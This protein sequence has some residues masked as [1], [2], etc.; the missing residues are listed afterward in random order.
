MKDNYDDKL[1]SLIERRLEHS[2]RCPGTP[3]LKVFEAILDQ[4]YPSTPTLDIRQ[5]LSRV[6]D[7]G[8][9]L[10]VKISET[11]WFDRG[12]VAMRYRILFPNRSNICLNL[13]S[14]VQKYGLRVQ[15]YG[16]SVIMDL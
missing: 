14:N 7:E 3:R 4:T 16:S 2:K 1:T 12:L 11:P 10:K 15:E 9:Q 5:R 8:L 6:A 13:S